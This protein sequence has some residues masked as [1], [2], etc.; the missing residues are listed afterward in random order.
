MIKLIFSFQREIFIII[1]K[2][3]E[4]F[5]SDRK[6]HKQVRII[7]VDETIRKQIILSRNKLPSWIINFYDLTKEEKE[8][9]ENAKTE[10]EIAKI[11]IKDCETK[12]GAKLMKRE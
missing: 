5:Y 11:C 2:N 10:E 4:I 3:K 6:L 12:C 1:I 7:P 8:Q 9:Y